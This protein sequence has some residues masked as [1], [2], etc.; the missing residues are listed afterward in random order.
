[1]K[2]K[3]QIRWIAPGFFRQDQMLPPP[4]GAIIAYSDGKT[5]W[6]SDPRGVTPMNASVL[7][8]AQGEILREWVSLILSDREA[9]RTVSGTGPKSA[10]ISTAD[11]QS[12]RVEFDD[13]TGLPVR[14]FYKET[15]MGGPPAEIKE[16]FSDWRDVDGIKLPFKVLMEQNDQKVGEVA[17]SE[18]KIN[19]GIK[20]EELNKKPEPPK[21]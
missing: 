6:L 15:G 5:G 14:V 13:A 19:T 21:K 11:G 7:R 2:M 16:T 1:M 9:S 10:E 12:V 17:I 4:M 20:P 8:Q 18:I 3:Q